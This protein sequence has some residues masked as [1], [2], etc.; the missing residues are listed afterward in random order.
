MGRVTA[1]ILFTD[2]VGSTEL[3]GR[4]GEE[5]AEELRR[6]HDRLLADA[7]EQHDGRV[8]KGLG[9]G[10]MASFAGASDAVAA[11][12]AI[13][14][15]V[16]RLNR[17]GKTPA[18]LAVRV[19][20]SAGDVTVEGDD[21]HGT[22]VIEAS[23][24][25]AA[26]DG[27]EILASEVVR[28]LAGPR[29]FEFGDR[30]CLQLKGLSDP[31]PAWQVA[32]EPATAST[33][34]MPALLTEVG[35]IFV[36]RSAEVERLRQLWK[37]AVAG[38]RRIALLAGEPGVGKTRLAADVASRVHEE[39][40]LVLAGR[41][42]EDLGV[43][44]QPFVEALRH[45]IDHTPPEACRQQL[46]RYGGELARL[47]PD[48]SERAPD[49]PPP[50]TSDAETERYR[51]F[52]AVAAWL[53]AVS[54]DEPVV[55]VLDDLQWAA[56]P[57]LLLLRHVLH[58]PEPLRLLVVATYRDTDIGRGHPLGELL[59]DLRR[60][61]GVD[62][63]A[64]SGLSVADVIGFLE[65]AGGHAQLNEENT[66]LAVALHDE[67]EGN[68][69]F[70]REV[71]RHLAE[72]GGIAEHDGRW[73]TTMDVDQLGIPEGVRDVVGRR[74]S[75]LS[76]IANRVLGHASVIG[77]EF[78]LALLAP[79]CELDEDALLAAL[80]EAQAARLV[81]ELPSAAPRYR[82]AHTL[83]RATLYEELSAGRRVRLHR[84]V[85]EAIESVYAGRLADHLTALA[86]HY[87]RAAAPAGEIGAKAVGYALEAGRQ[88]L[89]QLAYDEAAAWYRRALDLLDAGGTVT[90]PHRL[91]VLLALG[92]AQQ[93]A[94]D[95]EHRETLLAA[96]RAAEQAGR[97][98]V[99]VQAA[100]ANSR[101]VTFSA[102]GRRRTGGGDRR[103]P[104]G[105]GRSGVT[106]AGPSA[107]AARPGTDLGAGP[108]PPC[109][110]LRR[111]AGD[112]PAG[113]HPGSPR[114]SAAPALLHDLVAR[115]AGREAGDHG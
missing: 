29:D 51:L 46:G 113:R 66:A 69:F 78:D 45:F 55:L 72:T 60:D 23:R 43:P 52:D 71:L 56:K 75:R 73:S 110:V 109:G 24:L 18:T 38:E 112:R 79:V 35:R 100:L 108:D 12:L 89:D 111:G 22:P 19:G 21:A 105:L 101:E 20:L 32:W 98:D 10:V 37:Q 91:D 95:P 94:G 30:G 14:Q 107:G 85:A 103:G 48:L 8:V 63:L 2:L 3:R 104:A 90:G 62:R 39:G 59:A 68:P 81:A 86:H 1:T 58:F 27:G 96:A 57:T 31:V 99:V 4:L 25:C 44:Y 5:A 92:Q 102:R 36:G 82:F 97:T 50:L 11:A 47:L 33:M 16:D 42:D 70:L 6:R 13:Q 77:T 49:L 114:P 54:A 84:R 74:L 53:A 106:R 87:G 7:V 17:S 61:T 64:L 80:E 65:V 15:A 88:A 76:E 40:G 67:T 9:D 115:D 26:A 34:P 83:V 41:C 28:L 93:R